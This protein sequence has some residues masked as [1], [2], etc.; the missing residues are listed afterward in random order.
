MACASV[1]PARWQR[2][3]KETLNEWEVAPVASFSVLLNCLLCSP[4]SPSG[5]VVRAL[6]SNTPFRWAAKVAGRGT[7][8]DFLGSVSSLFESTIVTMPLSKSTASFPNSDSENR[9]PRFAQISKAVSIQGAPSRAVN[10]CRATLNSSSLISFFTFDALRGTLA[11]ASGFLSAHSRRMA[12][13][14][15][16]EKNF[17]SS[18]AVFC[19]APS[20]LLQSRKSCTCSKRTAAGCRTRLKRCHSESRAQASRYRFNDRTFVKCRSRKSGTQALNSPLMVGPTCASSLV[21]SSAIRCARRVALESSASHLVDRSLHRPVSRSLDLRIQKRDLSL[22]IKCAMPSSSHM[23]PHTSIKMLQN[24]ASCCCKSTPYAVSP[25]LPLHHRAVELLDF[26]AL[27][28]YSHTAP[29]FL[30]WLPVCNKMRL[31]TGRGL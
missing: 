30:G 14:M 22:R 7:Q 29:I 20:A 26:V 1:S 19:E 17:N 24:D 31:C 21:A 25:S 8:K 3:T 28:G 9:Q 5:G 23:L 13:C 11:N 12:S 16:K 27:A 2:V 15:T 4:L 10:A 18:R 6:F